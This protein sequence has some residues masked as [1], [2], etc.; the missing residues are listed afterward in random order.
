VKLIFP[1]GV[2]KCYIDETHLSSLAKIKFKLNI[3]GRK[4][5]QQEMLKK[6]TYGFGSTV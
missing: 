3:F 2:D 5:P 4:F 6:V 1:T